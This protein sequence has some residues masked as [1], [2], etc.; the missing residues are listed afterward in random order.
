MDIDSL[1]HLANH[2]DVLRDIESTFKYCFMVLEKDKTDKVCIEKIIYWTSKKKDYDTLMELIRIVD[3]DLVLL[4]FIKEIFYRE[5][6]YSI[7]DV[8][9]TSYIKLIRE[10][11]I[12]C[13]KLIKTVKSTPD[14]DIYVYVPGDIADNI[15]KAHKLYMDFDLLNLINEY[16]AEK[17]I[18]DRLIK[19]SESA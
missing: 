15:T 6:K 10:K 7:R 16:F 12:L 8:I 2:H 14:V 3:K 11:E 13:D 19:L 17:D 18:L 5:N 9:F 4:Q 1:R